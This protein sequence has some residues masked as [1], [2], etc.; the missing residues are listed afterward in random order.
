MAP[1][2]KAGLDA[3]TDHDAEPQSY[4]VTAL[5]APFLAPSDSPFLAHLAPT[6]SP[7]TLEPIVLSG[8]LVSKPAVSLRALLDSGAG[9][10]AVSDAF[11]CAHGLVRQ[12]L[13]QVA[14]ARLPNAATLPLSHF[15]ELPVL[16]DGRFQFT[17]RAFC[18]PLQ[19]IDL[20]L[21]MPWHCRHDAVLHTR[22]R[23]V[24][25]SYDGRRHSLA[26]RSQQ[27]AL[28]RGAASGT[29]G[30]PPSPPPAA[31]P[32]PPAP[33]GLRRVR[34]PPPPDL[35]AVRQAALPGVEVLS[36][37]QWRR[38]CRARQI[39]YAET[40]LFYLKV[41]PTGA[42]LTGS[43][44]DTDVPL[45]AIDLTAD[46]S[47][48]LAA[49]DP[50][51]PARFAAVL[52]EFDAQFKSFPDSLPPLDE[53]L[54]Q[55]LHL[56]DDTPVAARPYRLSP[57]Q[58]QACRDQL[59]KL[60]AAG[61]IRPAAS[62]Y[63][64]PV[65]MVP[66]AGQPGQWRLCV[67]Y[68]AINQKLVRDNFPLPH[69]ADVFNELAG[70]KFYSRLDLASGFWQ[71]RLHEADEPK[72]AFCA[73]S[74]GQF[75]WRVLPMG[76][77]VAP[78]VFARLMQKVLRP[79]LGRFCV[80]YL[81]DIGV[82]SDSWEDHLEHI[83]LVLQALREHHLFAKPSKCAFFLTELDFL[84]HLVSAQG[85]SV[86]PA[87]VEAICAWPTPTS[88]RALRSFLGLA[89]YYRDHVDNFSHRAGPLTDLLAAG[90]SFA[91]NDA[92]EAAF[93]D[94]KEALT[95]APVL[96]PFRADRPCT[97]VM[98]D[99]S[100]HGLGAVLM[101]A[102][103]DGRL[104][105]VAYHSR[106]LTAA[107]RNYPTREQE[108]LAV[109]DSLK[110]WRH[111]LLGTRFQLLTDHASLRYLTTQPHLSGRLFRWAQFLGEYDFAIA[112]VPGKQNTVADALSRRDDF[113]PQPVCV[114][115][116]DLLAGLDDPILASLSV[117]RRETRGAIITAQRASALCSTLRA[118]L[119]DHASSPQAPIH[120]AYRLE[121]LS[122]DDPAS[123]PGED[124]Q[125]LYWVVGGAHRLVVPE[126][127]TL[128][129]ALLQ[130][131]HDSAIGAHQGVDKT[132][133]RLSAGHYW[134]R[135][136][137]DVR[138]F[139]TSCHTCLGNKPANR[140]AGGLARPLLPPAAPWLHVGIDITGPLPR[141]SAGHT[142]M[143]VFVDHLSK[144]VHLVALAGSDDSPLSAPVLADAFFDIVVRQHGLPDAIISDRG[145]QW[146]SSFWSA[147][148]HRCGT[149]LKFSTAHHPQTDG[150][151]ERAI[152]TVG[153]AIRCCLDGLH[154][155]WH[156]HLAAVEL[157]Y[158]SSVHA[159]TGVSPFFMVY[160]VHPRLPL[161]DGCS[162]Q[163]SHNEPAF[164][165]LQARI[166]ARRRAAD[167][168][169]RAQLR[170]AAQIDRHRRPLVLRVHD[171][172]WLSTRN[173]HLAT[174]HKFTPKYLGPF[175][176]T[177]VMSS[178]NAVKLDLPPTIRVAHATFN[179]SQLREASGVSPCTPVRAA[180]TRREAEGNL[181]SV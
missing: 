162:S 171:L 46:D 175:A 97:L 122:P 101:Q 167:A 52:A 17:V 93:K 130:E 83:R 134:P 138:A 78:S 72:T 160:G 76:L 70:H 73:P 81:D 7:S 173:L 82:Y 10:D 164:T 11:A 36:A 107:E 39:D 142:W 74:V 129:R 66:K 168:L 165:F 40:T 50:A 132:Y 94:I 137:Q 112:H 145:S 177:Q 34:P 38:A 155:N 5:C 139:V 1:V 118:R 136:F 60:L 80:T 89:N 41:G 87:K 128:R 88:E 124:N 20:I 120:R 71:I 141:T 181:I 61:L 62:P 161:E 172:V 4:P 75:A 79:F 6:A 28:R 98:S 180:V 2:I 43:S 103:T 59:H 152:R 15:V 25:F 64:A 151:S 113:L 104:R 91:W 35:L 170:Q 114:P 3:G 135:M 140:A 13:P 150:A 16:F 44:L 58:L 57:V 149:K 9:L 110:A 8:S 163:E 109:V 22:Q 48:R 119:L 29:A 67:D 26:S 45:Y 123:S 18:L 56:T 154:D 159:S 51:L 148:F 169:A 30:L 111:Y 179:L 31:V 106:K 24:E 55:K 33:S 143:T 121:E 65:L 174:P 99:A 158:N 23:R 12:P 156:N 102:D 116:P 100:S 166:S 54:L 147:L 176:V 125:V 117:M 92:A 42:A 127:V 21:G 69:P 85:I 131:A 37:K 63:A 84:G 14:Q 157:A 146:L 86:D 47:T 96:Q 144:Q 105:P 126:D 27:P 32:A 77:K 53:D 115:R 95:A 19:G 68:R 108:L 153:D 133:A 49:I 90:R 178:G